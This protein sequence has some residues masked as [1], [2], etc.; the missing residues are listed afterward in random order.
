M[1]V[2]SRVGT[3]ALQQRTISDFGKVQFDLANVQGQISSGFKTNNFQ[4]MLGDIEQFTGLEDKMR[5]IQT[6]Q[7]N[8]TEGISRLQ[9]ASKAMDNIIQIT[10]DVRAALTLRRS[11]TQDASDTA[12]FSQQVLNDKI[13]L[14]G[15]LN[16]NLGGRF[17]FG[18]TRTD[19]PPVIVDPSI[20]EPVV[21]GTPDAGY[22]NGS[23]EDFTIRAEDNHDIQYNV[24]ADD[25]AFQKVFAAI[26]LSVEASGTNDQAKLSSAM[27]MLSSGL[28]GLITIKSS[29]NSNLVQ[30]QNINDRHDSLRLY[31]KGV[32]SDLIATDQVAASTQ[33]SIDQ[34]ILNASFKAFSVINSLR[35]VDFI[36]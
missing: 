12:A 27:D 13:S 19:T 18:G 11:G 29:M 1:T 15:L 14:A 35:L 24:R 26:S 34:T 9:T 28:D 33:I 23:L 5:R 30:L 10:E 31:L 21:S 16:T 6:Y 7:N 2:V 32:A 4:G 20:P 25:E 8:V 22:Y 36:K 17:L 3:L